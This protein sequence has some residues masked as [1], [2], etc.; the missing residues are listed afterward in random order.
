M[1]GVYSNTKD[2]VFTIELAPTLCNKVLFS[3]TNDTLRLMPPTYYTLASNQITIPAGQIH[4]GVEVHLTDAFFNDPLA[5]K[6][7]Y[8]IPLHIVNVANLD[9]V[10]R[11]S[12]VI[13]KLNPDQGLLLIGRYCLKTLLCLALNM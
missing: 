1:G 7:T 11:G 4:G 5:L 8:V 10:L 3:A 6:L 13:G 2:R 12:A 9:S